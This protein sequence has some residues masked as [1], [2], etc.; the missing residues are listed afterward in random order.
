MRNRK[1]DTVQ[2]SHWQPCCDVLDCVLNKL[3]KEKPD[4]DDWD[5]REW[6]CFNYA[7]AISRRIEKLN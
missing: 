4:Q 5:E 3:L 7:M 1:L 6:R 2:A